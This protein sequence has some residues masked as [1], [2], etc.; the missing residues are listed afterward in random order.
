MPTLKEFVLTACAVELGLEAPD[1][2][3][4]TLTK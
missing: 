4:G 3:Q 2:P 1:H